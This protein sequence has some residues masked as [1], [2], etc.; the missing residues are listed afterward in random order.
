ML[1]YWTSIIL[2]GLAVFIV[3]RMYFQDE[4]QFKASEK[5]GDR[6][7]QEK[8]AKHGLILKVS[9]IFFKRYISPIVSNMKNRRKFRDKYRRP[10][11]NAGLSE[12]LSPEDFFSFK[13]FLIIGFPIFFLAL[14]TVLKEDWALSLIPVIAGFGFFYPNIWLKGKIENRQKE[15]I[16]AFPFCIDMLA[17]SVEAG[18]D[19]I[20]SIS[21]VVEKG[22]PSALIEELQTVLKE[23]KI[24]ASRSEA[25]RNFSWRADMIQVSSF[26]ATLIAADSVGASIGSILKNISI[27][28]RQ[29][30]SSDVEK[31]AA[32]AATK[33]LFPMMLFI[34]PAVLLVTMAPTILSMISGNDK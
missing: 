28:V 5:L 18:L 4:E 22:R 32:K 24:G 26:C 23:I 17:L 30:K 14:R 15:I 31:S 2:T 8:V 3:T 20:A 11:A 12:T 13:L 7:L 33:I 16:M 1:L 25:L 34:V 27:E 10:L 29:K 6:E 9:H 21:K 19:F